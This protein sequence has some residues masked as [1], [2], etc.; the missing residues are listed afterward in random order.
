MSAKTAAAGTNTRSDSGKRARATT[1]ERVREAREKLSN[2]IELK[3]ELEYGLMV[4]FAR[5]ELAAQA[6]LIIV[7]GMFAAASVFWAPWLQAG[8]WL[9]VVI[10]AKVVQLELCRRFLAVPRP[11]VNLKLW[12]SYFLLSELLNGLAWAG[13][14]LVGVGASQTL[15]KAGAPEVLDASMSE[16]VFLFASLVVVL[17]VRMAFTATMLPLLNIGTLP[18]T[19]AVVARLV[20]SGELL[21]LSLG[22]MA[23]AVHVYF[24]VLARGLQ[25]TALAMLQYRAAKDT[26]VSEL[27]EQ[28]SIA[29]AA[30]QRA[31]DAN[32]AKSRFLA[33][34]SHELRT[35]LNAILGFSEVMK[36]ELMG[37]IGNDKYKEYASNIHTSGA[38]LLNLINEILDLSRIEAGRYE[39][40]E[41]PVRL[42]DVVE[43]S[44][45]LMKLR[46]SSKGL[47][48]E[49]DLEPD[50]P[51]LWADE[52]AVR[53]IVLNL[54]SNALKFTPRNGTVTVC[55][56]KLPDGRQC[57]A[58]ADTGPG[59]PPEEIP[60]VLQAFGQGSL[61]HKTAEGGTGLGLSIVQNIVQL[62]DGE[63]DL[64]SELRKGTTVVIT[65]PK[66]RVMQQM[67]P[68]QPLGQ[69][70]HKKPVAKQPRYGSRPPAVATAPK[71]KVIEVRKLR[72]AIVN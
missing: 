61:A 40:R 37:P 48:L 11:D 36:S 54:L 67:A 69:E 14:A 70:R 23:L 19:L 12:R 34:M 52:R 26:L 20:M 28:K 55:V 46:A 60:K 16:P 5:N 56:A 24:A 15:A 7:A 39:L 25:S 49:L 3:P 41:E 8:I 45:E 38:H 51:Q 21:Q 1:S 44:C 18:M 35:P 33:T 29:E 27:E 6:T 31:E 43:D 47:H 58:V 4:L 13:F 63:F 59:I 68:L 42:A 10:I 57:L 9:M 2:G 65:F 66:T 71:P 30:R 50:L 72:S 22:A 64:Q 62:H 32:V 53:Q 17:A